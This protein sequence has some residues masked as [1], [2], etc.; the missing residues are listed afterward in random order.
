MDDSEKSSS[1]RQPPPPTPAQPTSAFERWRRKAMLVT[2][3]GV[4]EEERLEDLRMHQTRQCEKTKTYLMNYSPPVVFMLQHLKLSGCEVPPQNILCAPCDWSRAGGF[5]PDPGAVVLCSGHFFSQKHMESTLVHELVHMY[6]HCK[7]KVDWSNLR[8]HACSELEWR[9]PVHT[10]TAPR[11]RILL[12]TAPGL[13]ATPSHNFGGRKPGVPRCCCGRRLSTKSG[14][15]V[16]TTR[17]RL[18]RFIEL[19]CRTRGGGVDRGRIYIRSSASCPSS[20][21]WLPALRSSFLTTRLLVDQSPFH[22]PPLPATQRLSPWSSLTRSSITRFAIANNV[23]PEQGSIDLVLPIVPAGA[24]YTLNAVDIGN[25]N[26]HDIA[27]ASTK[28]SA[29]PPTSGGSTISVP[30]SSPSFGS[31]RTGGSGNSAPSSFNGAS[32]L[33]VNMNIGAAAAVLFS[34]VAGAAIVAL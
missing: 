8:H 4:T 14:I 7:F 12:Q 13:C 22:G 30:A 5:S 24:G 32:A 10:R 34:A 27:A 18:M 15:A 29:G 16:S 2:G 19:A 25:I 33:K 9:L 23:I 28:T 3:L 21:L 17:G 1:S 20:L 11:L 31:T 26:N 6:D